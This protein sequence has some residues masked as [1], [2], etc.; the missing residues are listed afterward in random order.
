MSIDWE[1]FREKVNASQSIVL[2]SHVR[3]DCDALGSELGMAGVL[4]ALGKDVRIVNGQ[5]T[6]PSLQFIDPDR[7]I[8]C[9]NEDIPADQLVDLDLLIVLDTSAWIQLGAMSDVLRATSAEKIIVDHHVSEDDLGAEAFKDVH[10]PA[11]GCLVIQAAD[12]LEVPITKQIATPLFAA[13]ATDT[14][15]YRFPSASGETYRDAARLIDAGAMPAEIYS[16]LYERETLGRIR[17]RGTALQRVQTEL[18]GTLT[19]THIAKEDYEK[20]GALPTDTEDIINLTLRIEGTL[21]AIILIEQPT[22]GVKVSFRSRGKMDCSEVAASFGGGGHRAAAGAL[23]EG[24]VDEV[25]KTVLPV[26][27]KAM[28]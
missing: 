25:R 11:T 7:R 12:A 22:G 6:P 19:H 8:L 24:S 16:Q 4:D 15:W 1:R 23:L 10:A 5:A 18:N 17:L 27:L 28:E 20:T 26:V 14:G 3:P 2:T 9:V 13:I 21:G